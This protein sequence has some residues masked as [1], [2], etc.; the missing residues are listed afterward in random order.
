M[1]TIDQKIEYPLHELSA[2]EEDLPV[3]LNLFWQFMILTEVY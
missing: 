1:S 2:S 3:N